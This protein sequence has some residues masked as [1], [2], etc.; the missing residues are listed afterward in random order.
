M[1]KKK[2]LILSGIS[3][4][5]IV[6]IISLLFFL[7]KAPKEETVINPFADGDISNDI[8]NLSQPS[9]DDIYNF[10][11]KSPD[12]Q[13]YAY[14]I[15]G[16]FCGFEGQYLFDIKN[17][18]IEGNKFIAYHTVYY[19]DNPDKII[20]DDNFKKENDKVIED[21]LKINN[22]IETHQNCVNRTYITT[23]SENVNSTQTFTIDD[24]KKDINRLIFIQDDLLYM[25][26]LYTFEKYTV[27]Y[28]V[29]FYE[30]GH[31]SSTVTV[32]NDANL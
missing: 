6:A 9:I 18:K 28:I 31:I 15:D 17:E 5:L 30:F 21:I 29:T 26:F 22:F 12:T 1:D 19:K 27:S 2:I 23:Y 11:T 20:L 7:P 14:I 24:I 10:A 32:Y 3:V 4:V 8:S 13:D 25:E 16:V